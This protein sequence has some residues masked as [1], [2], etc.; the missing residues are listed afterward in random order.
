MSYLSRKI[1]TPSSS[2]IMLTPTIIPIVPVMRG[3]VLE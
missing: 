2:Q 1:A 3:S